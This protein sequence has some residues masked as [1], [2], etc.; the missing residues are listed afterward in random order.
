MFRYGLNN[1][2]R[3]IWLTVAATAVMSVTLI[4]ILV[5]LVA[6]NVLLETVADIGSKVDMS[7]YLSS[8]APESKIMQLKGQIEGLDNVK[9]VRYISAS[10]ARE[11]QAKQNK[12]DGE[13]LE[14]IKEAANRLPATLRVYL[15]D[16]NDT[17]SLDAFIKGSKLFQEIKDPSKEPSFQGERRTAISRI[18]EW[19]KLAEIGGA[20]MTVVFTI[21]SS[22]V[23][24]NTIRMAIFNRR[25]EIQMMKLIGAERA[26]IRGPFLVEAAMYGFIAA[27][28]ATAAGYALVFAAKA[29]LAQYGLPV[30]TTMSLMMHYVGLVLLG[31]IVVG[32]FIGI[33]SSYIATRKYL[34]I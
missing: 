22:L 31:M 19:V 8:E 33:V 32:A 15:V 28:V 9:S 17:S 12:Q 27:I 30:D 34:K 1:F 26:F 13:T 11:D 7:V 2:S 23:V 25:D 18:A 29:P 10:E 16:I 20:V 24:F 4:I 3:N 21:I 6:R 5:T 14:A